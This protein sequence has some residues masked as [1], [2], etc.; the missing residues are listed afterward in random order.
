MLSVRTPRIGALPGETSRILSLG[1][2]FLVCTW[3]LLC[4]MAIYEILDYFARF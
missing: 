2:V 3:D 4:M 1:G